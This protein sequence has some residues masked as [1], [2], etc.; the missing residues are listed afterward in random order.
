[1]RAVAGVRRQLT[2]I[3]FGKDFQTRPDNL[4]AKMVALLRVE[5]LLRRFLTVRRLRVHEQFIDRQPLVFRKRA[6]V[7]AKLDDREQVERFLPAHLLRARQNATR[8]SY[9]L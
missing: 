7:Y 1:M 6:E 3:R 9:S 2:D 5:F 8:T 4:R